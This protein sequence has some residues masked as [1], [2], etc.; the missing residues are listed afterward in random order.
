M[1]LPG[2]CQETMRT[3]ISAS[4]RTDLVSFFPKWLAEALR[5]REATVI[6][7]SG[8]A[9][10]VDLSP[11]AVHTLV[12]WSKDFS[13]VL[14]NEAGLR[15]RLAAYDQV[16]LHF[17]VT[18][19]GGT[20]IEPGAPPFLDGLAQLPRLVELAGHPRR[21][22]LRF[23]PL[24]FWR[25]GGRIVGNERHFAAAA[26]A[27]AAAGIVDLRFSFAQW[28]RK[29]RLRAARRGFPFHDPP[30]EE[31]RAVAARL[32]AA[33][34]G[35]NLKLYACSQSFLSGI[36]GIEPSACIEGRLLSELHPRAEPASPKKDRSQ[37][38]ECLCTESRDIGSY[39]QPCP[40]G[41]VYCYANP[42]V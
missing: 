24:L 15:T 37:R 23:D 30:E 34:G 6:G 12:L 36:G 20:M 18:G 22:S 5:K 1:S 29:A 3:V 31:K 41:C 39:T 21:V 33:A 35:H 7:P 42:A 11:D 9:H 26:A 10:T 40:H 17:T 32:A 38:A 4:R 19:L 16:Y 28:Y 13:N 25:E 27:A 8:R 14:R 2:G